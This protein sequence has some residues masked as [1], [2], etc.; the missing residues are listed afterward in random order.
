MQILLLPLWW[1]SAAANQVS[2]NRIEVGKP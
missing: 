2:M 1:G